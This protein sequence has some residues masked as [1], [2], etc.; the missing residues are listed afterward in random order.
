VDKRTFSA[1]LHLLRKEK[2][3]TQEQLAQKL[4]V[5][6]QAVSKWENGSYPEGDLLPAI[7][8]FFD[9]SID[10]LYGRSDRDKSIEQKTFEAVYDSMVKE[11]EE[12]GRTDGHLKTA[13]LIR[14]INWAIHTGLWVNNQSYEA[15]SRDPKE[16]PKMASIMC[17]D[18]FYSY[19]GLGED[20]DISFFLNRSKDYDLY[21]ELLKDTE[22]IQTL[23][24]LLSD[25]DNIS[26]IAFLYT[27]KLG[28]FVSVDVISKSIGIDKSKVKKLMDTLFDDMEFE[29]APVPPF[30]RASVIDASGKEEKIY[31]A[32]SIYGG[33]FMAM[34]M[35]AREITDSPQAFRHIINAKQKS[36]I[37]RNKFFSN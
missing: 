35:V 14:N 19:F 22:K 36:W 26:I 28:E 17:D 29:N 9:V 3:V 11:Y 2:K 23:F 13:N 12:T 16:Y 8:D 20:N 1:T 27:L 15:P 18:V 21:E 10:Y 6:P 24:K 4:G 32:N 37:D 25:K 33:L 7:A 5:S 31:S 34:M 30:N